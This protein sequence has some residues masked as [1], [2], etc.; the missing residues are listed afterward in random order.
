MWLRTATSD[1]RSR[2]EAGTLDR[3]GQAGQVVGIATF[4]TCQRRLRNEP[5]RPR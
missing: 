4:S 5:P 2:V 1:G 3:P